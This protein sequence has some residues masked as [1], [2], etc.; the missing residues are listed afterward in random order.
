MIGQPVSAIH[1][2]TT[3][4]SNTIV[5][6]TG[7]SNSVIFTDVPMDNYFITIEDSKNYQGNM[8]SLELLNEQIIQPTFSLFIELKPQTNSFVAL[9]LENEK[10]QKITH[11]NV[12]AILLAAHDSVNTNRIFLIYHRIHV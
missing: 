1:K 7:E 6:F 8:K 12:T 2:V 11:A 4:T 5:R 9:T 10:G 3:A